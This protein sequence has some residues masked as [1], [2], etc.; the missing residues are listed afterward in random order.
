MV[1]KEIV[2]RKPFK[3]GVCYCRSNDFK[4]DKCKICG[5]KKDE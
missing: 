1:E 3:E 2:K 4:D 5:G